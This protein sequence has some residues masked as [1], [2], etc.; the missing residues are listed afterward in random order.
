MAPSGSVAT[1]AKATKVWIR[2]VFFIAS[3]SSFSPAL[4]GRDGFPF[5]YGYARLGRK[6]RTLKMNN[7]PHGAD[8]VVS[9]SMVTKLP[10]LVIWFSSVE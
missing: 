4:T 9:F 5:S 10:V 1:I 3:S 6:C 8:L 7:F 2:I